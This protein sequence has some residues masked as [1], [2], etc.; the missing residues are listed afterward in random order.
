MTKLVE[1]HRYTKAL[2]QKMCCLIVNLYFMLRGLW[3]SVENFVHLL[4]T[5]TNNTT[6]TLNYE[7]SNASASAPNRF[8]QDASCFRY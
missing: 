3:W 7:S 5:T 1:F 2:R 8:G 6:P 4:H